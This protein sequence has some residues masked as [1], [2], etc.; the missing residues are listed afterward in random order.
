MKTVTIGIAAYNAERNITKL[1]D[2]L[3]G[4]NIKNWKFD[5]LLIHSDCSTDQTVTNI[6]K[7]K[8]PKLKIIDNKDRRG[9]AG[10][11]KK[12]LSISKSDITLL[13]NDDIK[14]DDKNFVE[15]IVRAF[16]SDKRIGLATARPVP[17]T[18]HSFIEKSVISTIT[19]YENTI[20]GEKIQNSIFTCDGK[21]MAIGKEFKS[22]IKFPENITLA[23]NVDSY[24]YL[25]NKI[26]GFKYQHI[27][28]AKV[29][30]RCPS[31]LKDWIRWT[32]RNNAD[33][34]VLKQIFGPTVESEFVF[35]KPNQLLK[36][37]LMATVR[38]P[39]ES[40]FAFFVGQYCRMKAQNYSTWLT[41]KWDVVATSKL[42]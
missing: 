29:L 25:S 12:I 42:L 10:S 26:N 15:K 20:Y 39:V 30:F 31:T 32:S 7:I 27:E 17:L 1:I 9:F 14:I 24:I 22:K 28:E 11:V 37:K 21:V 23:G 3:L 2:I 4:Q 35:P 34:L 13:L 38:H 18:P 6:Q 41:A 19:A 36:N 8:N 16:N 5:M 40:I 33:K